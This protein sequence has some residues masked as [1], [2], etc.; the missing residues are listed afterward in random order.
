MGDVDHAWYDAWERAMAVQVSEGLRLIGTSD[1]AIANALDV[2]LD[3]IP[4]PR[5]ST[6]RVQAQVAFLRAFTV[7]M[8]TGDE[9]AACAVFDEHQPFQEGTTDDA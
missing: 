6:R 9:R 2:L 8:R 3:Q 4:A 5:Y 1:A 7:A